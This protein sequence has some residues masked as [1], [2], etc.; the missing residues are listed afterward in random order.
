M[1]RILLI[2]DNELNRELLCAMMEGTGYEIEQATNGAE[3]L[4][5]LERR[6][7]DLVL[8]DLQMPVMGGIAFL[9]EVR[10]RPRLAVLKV[11]AVSAYAMRG[12]SERA[13]AEGFDGYLTK[14]VQ[15][16]EL[17]EQ[18]RLLLEDVVAPQLEAS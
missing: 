13:L 7:P 1:K 5:M 4:V 17:R 11:V 3:A 18:I 8:T 6:L 12:D 2:E 16:A 15:K 9:E 10:K 14:P